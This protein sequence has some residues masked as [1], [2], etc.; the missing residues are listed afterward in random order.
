[1]ILCRPKIALRL[2]GVK[3]GGMERWRRKWGR[4]CC[5]P[6]FGSREKI[7]EGENRKEIPWIHKF[8]SPWFWE[9][10]KNGEKGSQF[11]NYALTLQKTFES[12]ETRPGNN[13]VVA[14]HR[15]PQNLMLIDLPSTNLSMST[16]LPKKS[17]RNLLLY[18]VNVLCV[19]WL[20][21][22]WVDDECV[23]ICF[24]LFYVHQCVCIVGI[25]QST[26]SII[27]FFFPIK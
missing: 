27:S 3:M 18:V 7:E 8:S 15:H 6:L 19:P 16:S 20:S 13:R 10:K 1:M 4:K 23:L 24:I 2:V 9:E 22:L 11:L 17:H 5:F 21:D 12:S 26:F 25:Q 14:I